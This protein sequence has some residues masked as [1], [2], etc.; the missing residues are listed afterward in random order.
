MAI[1]GEQGPE[2]VD[3][4]QGSKVFSNGKSNQMMGMAANG[5]DAGPSQLN[6]SILGA[7][8]DNHIR[9]LVQQG[10]AEALAAKNEQDRRG[11]FGAMQARYSSQKG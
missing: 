5:N 1:V 11:G 3:L 10:V 9:M 7:S 6:V 2:L 4:P 8:G